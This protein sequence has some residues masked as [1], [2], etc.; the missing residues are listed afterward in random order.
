MLAAQAVQ[1]K[2]DAFDLLC[3]LAFNAP[4]HT[5]RER[6][7]RV[8]REER[9]FFERFGP[10]ARAVL[11]ELLDKYAEHGTDEFAL[12]DALHVPPISSRGTVAEI[13]QLFGGAEHMRT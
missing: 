11:N 2:A 4:I 12:P 3:H 5:R 13:V 7:Q 10:E 9:E 8:K 1:P 6:A